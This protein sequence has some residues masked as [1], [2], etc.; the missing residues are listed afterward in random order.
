M[1]EVF[2]LIEIGP[3]TG[4]TMRDVIAEAK[5]DGEPFRA[6]HHSV[7]EVGLLGELALAA[8]GSMYL[9]DV[10]MF[11]RSAIIKMLG[12]WAKMDFDSRPTLFAS[13][14]KDDNP[15]MRDYRPLFERAQTIAQRVDEGY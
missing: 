13:Y 5:V 7:S 6:P 14:S 2:K 15:R 11:R 3:R 8:G 4:V 9:A 1:S 12:V 10:T